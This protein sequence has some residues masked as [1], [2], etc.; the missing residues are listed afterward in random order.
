MSALTR[1]YLLQMSYRLEKQVD[2][3]LLK[4]KLIY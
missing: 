2:L 1:M 4:L 3:L